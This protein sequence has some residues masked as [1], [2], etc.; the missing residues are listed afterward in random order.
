MAVAQSSG[1]FLLKFLCHRSHFSGI[2]PLQHPMSPVPVQPVA[3]I[4]FLDYWSSHPVTIEKL[5]TLSEVG[6]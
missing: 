6:I 5:R 3:I 1:G 2:H 4:I